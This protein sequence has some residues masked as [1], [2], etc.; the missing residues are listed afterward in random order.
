MISPSDKTS[1][2]V[3]SLV[4]PCVA[5]GF[6][7]SLVF[8]PAGR[9]LAHVIHFI[10]GLVVFFLGGVGMFQFCHLCRCLGVLWSPS[11]HLN[12]LGFFFRPVILLP[13]CLMCCRLATTVYVGMRKKARALFGLTRPSG[14]CT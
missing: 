9:H 7:T 14:Y 10:E 8:Q 13:R 5:V 2:A 1:Q 11:L 3:S 6:A 4:G 12:G